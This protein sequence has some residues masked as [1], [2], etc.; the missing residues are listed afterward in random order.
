MKSLLALAALWALAGCSVATGPLVVHSS[1]LGLEGPYGAVYGSLGHDRVEAEVRVADAQ[2]RG[3]ESGIGGFGRVLAKHR[4]GKTEIAAGSYFTYQSHDD[5]EKWTAGPAILARRPWK[6]GTAE[7]A[8]YGPDG[9]KVS[10]SVA[11]RVS[12][13]GRIS[14]LVEVEKV[15]HTE[16]SGTRVAV[17][18]LWRLN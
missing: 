12:G 4:I 13:N 6:K 14:P 1:G 10:G 16:G 3:S 15:R 2:K 18:I 7:L 17:G 11:V 9:D 5:W 8:L